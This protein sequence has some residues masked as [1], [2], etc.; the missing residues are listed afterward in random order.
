MRLFSK[1]ENEIIKKLVNIQR[2][3]KPG[4]LADLQVARLL[5]KKLKFFAL[6][7]SIDP[8]DEIIIFTYEK[9]FKN[10][11]KI[12]RQYFNIADFIYF[13]EELEQLGFVKLQK[14]PSKNEDNYT[15]LYD[16]DKYDYD[17]KT[18][19]FWTDVELK[20]GDKTIK[21]KAL[22]P[23]KEWRKFNTDFA[24]DLQRCAL[25]IVYPLPLARE[26]VKNGFKTLEQTQF[27][28][29]MDTALDSAK[30]GRRAAKWGVAATIIAIFALIA[31]I[32]TLVIT[33][34]NSKKPTTIDR[35][36]LERIESAI[37]SNHLSE[38]LEIITNDMLVV[39]QVQAPNLSTKE[40]NNE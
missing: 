39:K 35:L 24:K 4:L 22:V 38:P 2:K 14:I 30:S 40:T 23:L 8:I 34:C 33:I 16:R 1:P 20:N 17:K 7:W 6:Q 32:I 18:G 28:K 27:E 25:S 10:K 3:A 31:T 13:I 9:D 15:I 11:K 19:T 37:N 29:Q 26:Y 5:R 21:G 12:D 36:D